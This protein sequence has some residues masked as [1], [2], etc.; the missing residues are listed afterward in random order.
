MKEYYMQW[1]E[2]SCSEK[3]LLYVIV[4]A[5]LDKDLKESEYWTIYKAFKSKKKSLQEG[6]K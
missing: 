1:I 2:K 6:R 4:Q 5:G 3:M